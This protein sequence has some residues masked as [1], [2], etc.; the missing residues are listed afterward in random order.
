MPPRILGMPPAQ[1]TAPAKPRRLP[2]GQRREVIIEQAIAAFAEH[3]F[4]LGTRDLAARLGVTQALLYRYFAS[5][6]ELIAAALDRLGG[7]RWCADWERSLRDRS[8]PLAERLTA[9]YAAYLG[10][11]T[12]DTVRLFMR[13]NLEGRNLA[14]RFGPPLTE[15][16][17]GPVVEELRAETGLPGFAECPFVRGE[18]E[19][20]MALH[21]GVMF[22]GIR[23]HV[24][25]MP[26]PEELTELV[27]L[28]VR[29]FL[30]G[31]LVELAR[32]HG[33]DAEASLTVRQLRP[34]SR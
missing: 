30:P 8:A 13:A 34:A 24:Y 23:K 31:A 2:R 33:T 15:K 29:T 10:S 7:G 4:G 26:M 32:L 16:I 17:L 3:G 1:A 21:G 28:Q 5:K 11:A 19:L 27:A 20:A 6:E 18:R 22:L 25:R 9:F 12:P 14:R